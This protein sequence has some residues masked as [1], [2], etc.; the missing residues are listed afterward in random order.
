MLRLLQKIISHLKQ[1]R[2]LQNIT[3]STQ[4]LRRCSTDELVLGSKYR[5]YAFFITTEKAAT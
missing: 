4:S 2:N 1:F 3:F 5:E